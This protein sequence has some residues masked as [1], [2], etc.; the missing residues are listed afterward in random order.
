MTSVIFSAEQAAA[1]LWT[2]AE[3]GLVPRAEGLTELELRQLWKIAGN[4]WTTDHRLPLGARLTLDKVTAFACIE[5]SEGQVRPLCQERRRARTAMPPSLRNAPPVP[6]G[7][8][9]R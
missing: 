2:Y 5:F 7:T 6:P 3:D 4:H 1:A 9:V 8:D